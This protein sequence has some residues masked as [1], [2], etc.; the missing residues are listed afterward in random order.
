MGDYDNKKRTSE[1]FTI[2][3]K[4]VFEIV[5]LMVQNSSIGDLVPWS[6]RQSGTS[7]NQSLHNI[8]E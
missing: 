1:Y 6:V 8:T 5:F 2:S 3:S 4:A 7:N